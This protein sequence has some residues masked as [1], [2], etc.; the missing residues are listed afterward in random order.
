MR[1][2]VVILFAF[3]V[4]A[5]LAIAAPLQIDSINQAQLHLPLPAKERINPVL[6]KAQVLLDRAHFSP[7]E[8]DGKFGDNFNKA[9]R[10]FATAQGLNSRGELTDE[11]WQKLTA[12]SEEPVDFKRRRARCI[13]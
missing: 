1:W 12:T 7:G 9:L 10:A 4:F 2:H 3:I 5:G 8:I 13:R 11:V 6:I